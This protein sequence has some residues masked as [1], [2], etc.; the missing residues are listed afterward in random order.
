MGDF[1]LDRRLAATAS[2][3]SVRTAD[4]AR[5]ASAGGCPCGYRLAKVL[6]AA[7]ADRHGLRIAPGVRTADFVSRAARVRP[8]G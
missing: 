8:V 6:P 3:V 5:E 2:P 7:P 4:Q 1:N